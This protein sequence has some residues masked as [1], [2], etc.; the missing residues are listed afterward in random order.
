MITTY[1]NHQT[2]TNSLESINKKLKAA[3]GTGWINLNAA[4]TTMKNFKLEYR[5]EYKTKVLD[6]NLNNRRLTA[7]EREHFISRELSLY[8]MLPE[9]RQLEEVIA[10]CY[11]IGSINEYNVVGQFEK[12]IAQ[13][14]ADL[15]EDDELNFDDDIN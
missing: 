10:L 11:K 2:T 7:V 3:A 13:D 1:N 14:I 8:N 5:R 9:E 12:R 4:L 6:G 15:D